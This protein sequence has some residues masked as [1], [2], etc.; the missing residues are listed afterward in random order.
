MNN[1]I[2]QIFPYEEKYNDALMALEHLTPQGKKIKLE[3]LRPF[4]LS[5][6]E[7]FER[8]SVF[9][10]LAQPKGDMAG[11]SGVSIVPLKHGGI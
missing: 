4:F 2:F 3:M 5:R 10:A 6:S 7:V 1:E 11:V 9:V 8:Y